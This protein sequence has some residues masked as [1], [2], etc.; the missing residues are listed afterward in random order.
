[1][2]ALA[3]AARALIVVAVLALAGVVSPVLTAAN[4]VAASRVGQS[5]QTTTANTLKPSSCASITLS[6]KVS[7][8]GSF[9]GT[10]AANLLAGSSAVD[11]ISGL[12]GADCLLGGAG[13]DALDGGA[14]TDVCIGGPGTDTF[15][16]CETQI[17]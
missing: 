8:S 12:G 10:S 5:V 14:G 9:S 11:T 7:G 13:D 4:S 1:M 3:F 15:A 2:T 16:N 17:Q 6:T